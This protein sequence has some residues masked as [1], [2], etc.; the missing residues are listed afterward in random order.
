MHTLLIAALVAAAIPAGMDS[1]RDRQDAA[2]LQKMVDQY[3]QAAA[4]SPNDAD[5]QYRFALAA[6]YLAQVAQE[7][8]NKALAKSASERGIPAGEKAVALRPDAENYRV[9]GTLYGQAVTDLFSGLKYGPRAKAAIAKAVEK[10]P[11]SSAVY[12]ARGVGNYYLPEQ[13]GGGSKVA[14]ADFRKAIQLDSRNADAYLW[15]GVALRKENKNTE[16]R[17]AL[18]TALKLSPNRLWA[19]QQLDKTPKQ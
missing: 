18:A 9:L 5:A 8:R 16:A 4:K 14:I 13:M 15:L 19:K 6:S 3:A 11:N 1:A 17:D 7:V 12:V 2:A 10:A